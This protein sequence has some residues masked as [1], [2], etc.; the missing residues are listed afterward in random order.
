MPDSPP[1][2]PVAGP[3]AT[4]AIPGELSRMAP[5]HAPMLWR[6]LAFLVDFTLIGLVGYLILTRL[7]LPQF[8]PEALNATGRFYDEYV[9]LNDELALRV[10]E[11]TLGAE[12][13]IRELVEKM[14]AA[15][16]ALYEISAYC[17]SAMTVMFW[18]GFVLS[19]LLTGGASLGKRMFRL[20]VVTY[21][22]AEKPGVFDSLVRN[23]WK[24]MAVA[25][26]N[27]LA[28]FFGLLDVHWPLFNPL[29]RTLHDYLSRTLV[30]D[31]RFDPPEK[32]KSEE[33]ADG[34]DADN[35][36]DN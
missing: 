35:G 4:R 6:A 25:T 24:A 2:L 29:R 26:L 36:E 21:P 17:S 30:L 12:G 23:G 15:P 32:P 22:Y 13:A 14:R 33:V 34:E 1:P 5:P 10:S 19:E 16:E 27:P 20:R 18:I 28:L 9:Q 3:A 8:M 7:L 31:A 11:G